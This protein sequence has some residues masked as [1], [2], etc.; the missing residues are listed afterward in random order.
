MENIMLVL[1]RTLGERIVL[2]LP[3]GKRIHIAITSIWEKGVRVGVDAPLDVNI[4]REELM[5][6]KDAEDAEN[7]RMEKKSNPE[8]K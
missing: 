7:R 6:E 2:V 8:K 4:Y 3:D 5:R 1:T